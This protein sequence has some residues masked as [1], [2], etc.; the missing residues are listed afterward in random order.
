VISISILVEV[1]SSREIKY[2][3]SSKS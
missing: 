1:K 3:W 2:Y